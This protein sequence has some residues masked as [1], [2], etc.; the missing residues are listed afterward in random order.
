MRHNLCKSFH[1]WCPG[2]KN[3]CLLSVFDGVSVWPSGRCVPGVCMLWDKCIPPP[4]EGRDRWLSKQP[5]GLNCCDKR[6]KRHIETPKWNHSR[7][8]LGLGLVT[9]KLTLFTP[10][11][12]AL[13]GESY[14]CR[15]EGLFLVCSKYHGGFDHYTRG[16]VIH[17]HDI[18]LV[19]EYFRLSTR[20][21]RIPKWYYIGDCQG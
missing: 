19:L 4:R 6:G 21:F 18:D 11:E 2:V 20:K 9:A 5:R 3:R 8:L 15:R 1:P 10:A 12:M 14:A 17:S 7:R 13:V 16:Q